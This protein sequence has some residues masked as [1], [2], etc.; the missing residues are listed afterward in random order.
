[1][2]KVPSIAAVIGAAFVLAA[3]VSSWTQKG[4]IEVGLILPETGPLSPT[5]GEGR[6]RGP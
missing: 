5:G 1:M 2:R 6:V 3:S 4:P